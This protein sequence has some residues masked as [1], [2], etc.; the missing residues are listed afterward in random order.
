M[1]LFYRSGNPAPIRMTGINRQVERRPSVG[2]NGGVR[3]PAPSAGIC[4]SYIERQNLNV[5]MSIRRMTRLTNGFSK[6]W[7][8]H[9]AAIALYFAY[10]NF[11]W[12]HS[13]LKMTPAMAAGITDHK[14][15][16]EE[17]L[18]AE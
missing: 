13:T 2:Q 4:T 12:K 1:A 18:K 8:N 9:E 7:E 6:K 14:W 15:T 11:C 3:R 17:L 10:Y 5:R 16:I